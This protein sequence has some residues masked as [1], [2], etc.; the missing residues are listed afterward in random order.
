MI[1]VALV[2]ALSIGSGDQA[3]AATHKAAAARKP[4]PTSAA[5]VDPEGTKFAKVYRAGKAI[6]ASWSVGVNKVAMKQLLRDLATELTILQD[7]ALVGRDVKTFDAYSG[8]LD[9]FN[10]AV[11]LHWTVRSDDAQEQVV[12]QYWMAVADR[13]LENAHRMLRQ[14]PP[15]PDVPLPELSKAPAPKAPPAPT[16][17]SMGWSGKGRTKTATEFFDVP[18]PQ[19]H[20][21][22]NHKGSG[23]FVL[24]VCDDKQHVVASMNHDGPGAGV[25]DVKAPGGKFYLVPMGDEWAVTTEN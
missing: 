13:K 3:P 4:T 20:V 23:S 21:R 5:L 10:S 12:F 16:F 22:W 14:L 17:T 1:A 24:Q 8:A 2:I 15:L 18:M 19:W 6:Q 7:R 9:S 25:L 11:D